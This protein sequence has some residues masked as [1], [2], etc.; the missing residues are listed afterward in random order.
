MKEHCKPECPFR[1]DEPEEDAQ[2]VKNGGF[3][4][5]P[6]RHSREDVRIPERE[7]L[8]AMDLG[9]QKLFHP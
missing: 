8:V 7:G 9:E 2:R 6:I 1:R 4:M 5:S 3:K